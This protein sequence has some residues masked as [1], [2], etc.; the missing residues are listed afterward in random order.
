VDRGWLRQ[1]RVLDGP[2][3]LPAVVATAAEIASGVAFLHAR[4]IV[5]GDLSPYNILLRRC[6][7]Q[8]VPQ[9]CAPPPPHT[10]THTVLCGA[11]RARP[12][13][14]QRDQTPPQ[15]PASHVRTCTHP[16]TRGTRRSTDAAAALGGR[17]WVAKIADLG[18]AR[19]MN[20]ASKVHTKTYG[21]YRVR[22]CCKIPGAVFLGAGGGHRSGGDNL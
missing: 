5:H 12:A 4:G 18:L 17:G 19:V 16:P 13:C 2:V 3:H 10:H 11:W 15:R 20:T 6:A 7:L 22:A 8:G 1:G 14:F 9:G 21:A